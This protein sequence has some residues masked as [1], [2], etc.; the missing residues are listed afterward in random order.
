M[1]CFLRF[2][3]P[4]FYLSS[5]SWS[6]FLSHLS[7]PYC[8]VIFRQP[9]YWMLGLFWKPSWGT[10]LW[11]RS[12]VS[13][14]LVAQQ[15]GFIFIWG[16]SWSHHGVLWEGEQGPVLPLAVLICPSAVC[17]AERTSG[18]VVDYLQCLWEHYWPIAAD[19][20]WL[21]I[22]HTVSMTLI[23]KHTILLLLSSGSPPIQPSNTTVFL[24]SIYYMWGKVLLQF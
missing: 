16:F 6:R 2:Y 3:L 22:F 4:F 11:L 14:L 1:K 12:K 5:L 17:R 13:R 9:L 15:V 8:G 10:S 19:C 23:I 21:S 24:E 18:L 20:L 7:S